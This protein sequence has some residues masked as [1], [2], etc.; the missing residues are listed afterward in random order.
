MRDERLGIVNNPKLVGVIRDVLLLGA[1]ITLVFG[2]LF[3]AESF[4]WHITFVSMLAVLI[5]SILFVVTEL[6]HPFSSGIAIQ[7][8]G[9][10]KVLKMMT[11]K[12]PLDKAIGS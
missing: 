10:A 5:A 1:F 3:G 7:P 8:A 4:W 6:S 12:P 2:V 9:Y 11:L